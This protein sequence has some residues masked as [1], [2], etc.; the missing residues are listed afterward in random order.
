MKNQKREPVALVMDEPVEEIPFSSYPRPQL[1]LNSYICLNGRWDDGVLVPFPLESALSG[2][3]VSDGT[4]TD[5]RDAQRGQ[6][7]HT[8]R[9]QFEIPADFVQDKILLHFDAID[10]IAK[11]FVDGQ[12]AGEHTGGY[13]PF[14]CDIT[15][16]GAGHH[17]L[18]VET[19]DDTST[20]YPYGK[21]TLTPGG[22]W[23]TAISGIWQ[24]VWI[25]SVPESYIEKIRL[26][27]SL[28]DVKIEITGGSDT[29]LVRIYD[30]QDPKDGTCIYEQTHTQKTFTI[31]IDNPRLWSPEEPNLY[32]L[33]IKSGADEIVSY[34]GL[35]TVGV[36]SING[37]KRL[38]LNGKPYFFHGVLDQGYYPQGIFL[39]NNAGGYERDVQRMKDLGFNTLRKHIKIEHPAF[40][41]ACDRLGMIVFQDMVNNGP[42]SFFKDTALP[43][44]FHG[45]V[46]DK[47]R[48][49][50]ERTRA[51]FTEHAKETVAHLY[52]YP[53]ICYL[54]V[55][56]EGWGQFDSDAMY[57]KMKAWDA[58]R[59]ID[60]TSGW[61]KQKKSDVESVHCYFKPIRPVKSERPIVVSEMGGYSL[62][63]EGHLFNRNDNY[64][65]KTFENA[66]DL[67]DAIEKL[68][69][70]EVIPY[71]EAGLCGSIYTQL[72]DV[73]D[74]T[75]GF[76]TYDR[77]VC[78]VDKQA[79]LRIAERIRSAM[80]K[81]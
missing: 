9:R 38:C 69:G 59:I 17:E 21:Q 77:A 65:Y 5:G 42:Y 53:C 58:S 70:C 15:A 67:G 40:Y 80:Q 46:S 47:R 62:R 1:K 74:E 81:I 49:R 34:F 27:P 29:C 18:V 78:K 19:E 52:N 33:V 14:T 56:N 7:R 25:E 63:M 30:R 79:M 44:V 26:T 28:S 55:F 75:N 64:G 20:D 61:F 2:A 11:V 72:S 48:H 36:R 37:K 43:T 45:H 71:I 73:E 32:G 57:D 51:I 3:A 4:I 31:P 39:P 6:S 10:C 8:Y 41:E 76:Y 12:K 50:D 24:S 66:K 23:Y 16:S 54:T 68:Y 13:L 22:M 60:S 35:R